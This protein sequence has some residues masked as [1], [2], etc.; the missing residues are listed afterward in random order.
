M[1]KHRTPPSIVNP[2][3]FCSP[4]YFG[5]YFLSL[6][7][8]KDLLRSLLIFWSDS[9]LFE[10]EFVN[11]DKPGILIKRRHKNTRINRHTHRSEHA[12]GLQKNL[13]FSRGYFEKPVFHDLSFFFFLFGLFEIGANLVYAIGHTVFPGKSVH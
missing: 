5:V 7:S 4:A 12:S 3:V 11:Y 6:T 10:H 13:L 9:V 2:G 8:D 1:P